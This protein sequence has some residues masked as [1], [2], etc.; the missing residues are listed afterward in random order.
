MPNTGDSF[1]TTLRKAHLQWGLYRHTNSRGIIYGEGYLQIP[2]REARRLN[3]TNSNQTDANT[4]YIC[5]SSDHF[6]QNVPLLASGSMRS[7]DIYAKQ[8]QGRGNL[9]LLGD[10]FNHVNAKVGDRIKIEWKSSTEIYLT[11]L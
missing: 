10:W 4:I 7:G 1:I 3:I 6:L 5:N 2:I 8:F 9:R 11:K